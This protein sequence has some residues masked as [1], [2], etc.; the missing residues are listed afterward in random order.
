MLDMA[1]Q[2]GSQ[3]DR[4]R[5]AA[6]KFRLPYFDYYR[7]RSHT[8]TTFPGI[9]DGQTTSFPYDFSLP[10]IFTL[11]KV[12]LMKPGATELSLEDNP[13]NYF[14]F[15]TSGMIPTSEW[16]AV[17]P[18]ASG[19]SRSRTTRYPR[20][21]SDLEGDPAAM[22][23]AINQ[24]R[25]SGTGQ[26]LNMITDPAYNQWDAFSTDEAGLTPTSGSLEDIHGNYHVIIG[27]IP[28]HM[29]QVAV[30]AFDPVFWFH[31]W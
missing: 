22:N 20:S 10:Q 7:P 23:T 2:F 5:Q 8:T 18:Q 29:S 11:E 31:H 28:G 14:T 17:V 13:L 19:Y 3:A 4:Y 1:N 16:D 15:P 24:N 21:Q 30:A 12:M 25:E 26:I 9:T 27:N 6:Q